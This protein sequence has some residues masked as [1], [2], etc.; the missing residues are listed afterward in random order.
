MN[1]VFAAVTGQYEAAFKAMYDPIA[2]AATA[3]IKDASAEILQRGRANIASAGFSAKWQQGL[4]TRVTPASGNSVDAAVK[5]W[6][7][8]GYAT[9]FETGAAIH[10]KPLLWLPLPSLPDKIGGR[11]MTPKTFVRTIGPLF[12]I[13]VPGKHPMLGAYM[14]GVAGSKVTVAKL[15]R[16]SALAR[17][18]VRGRAG[19]AAKKGLVATPVFVGVNAV[20]IRRR[21]NLTGVY[22]TAETN[23]AANYARRVAEINR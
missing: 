22:E 12:S 13:K 3:A 15:R 14:Q 11:V 1:L 7:S 18:G 5:V 10:G 2:A 23:L 6:H 20:T 16:G 21:W 9:V 8:R 17:L 4:R 19:V